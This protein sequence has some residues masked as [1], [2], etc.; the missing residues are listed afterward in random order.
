MLQQMTKLPMRTASAAEYAWDEKMAQKFTF[1]SRYDEP[2]AL[3][4]RQGDRLWLPRGACPLADK[5]DRDYGVKV[6]FKSHWAARSADQQRVVAESIELLKGGDSHILQA[7]TGYGKTYLGCHIAA[8]IGRR[9]L[10]ITTKEDIVEQWAVAA[11]KTLWPEATDAEI[12]SLIG[13]WR[14]DSVPDVTCPIVIGLVQSVLKGYDRYG[15]HPYG[16]FGLVICDEVHRMA[17]DQFSQCMWWLPARLRLGMSATPYRRDG[18]DGVFRSHIGEVM[19][20][21]EMDVEVPKVL[22]HETGWKVPMWNTYGNPRPMEHSPGK[23]AH[24]VKRMAEDIPRNLQIVS[25]LQHAVAKER[26]TIVFSDTIAHLRELERLLLEAGVRGQ[27]IGYYVG[28][29]FYPGSKV[30]K[31][32]ARDEAK[33]KPIILAT[34]AMASEATDIPWL[35]TCVLATPRSDVVQI[36]GR[37]RREYPGKKQPVVYDLVDSA[38]RVFSMYAAKRARWY[39]LLG[40]EV[41]VV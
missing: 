25:F 35:D 11:R 22:V 39:R 33:H 41:K 23:I 9:T 21:A 2:Y 17:A 4:H 6:P 34:Y 29:S 28:S 10:I 3:W 26:A 12:R 13:I 31:T 15:T 27:D 7:P 37:I 5:D 40:A 30:E 14:G 19:V 38:S 16:G 32:R 1:L 36:V 20:S 24:V 18:K 8:N